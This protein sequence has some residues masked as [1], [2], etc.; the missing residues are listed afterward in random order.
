MIRE[1]SV[2]S[3]S[4]NNIARALFIIFMSSSFALV[5]LS[6][7]VINY[8][9]VVSLF[10]VMMFSVALVL[11]TKYV[12]PIY[13]YDIFID[14]DG[15]PLFIV[16]Q[17]LG[18]KQ[19]TL[20]RIGLNEITK[21]NA[22]SIKERREHKTALGVRKYSYLPT[23]A[24]T[25]AYRITTEGRYEKAEILIECSDEF[26][27]LLSDYSAQAKELYINEEY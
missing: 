4:S 2:K 19:S 27:D 1:F 16:R 14:S 13:Y 23:V 20:C 8:K 24:P 25:K 18:K 17:Q 21:I 15:Q 22:E 7:L 6:T 12:A 3:K 9:G 11:Y 5:L 26:A 10:G